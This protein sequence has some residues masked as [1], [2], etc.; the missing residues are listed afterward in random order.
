M[1]F[2][3][4]TTHSIDA[5]NDIGW[6][7]FYRIKQGVLFIQNVL[8]LGITWFIGLNKMTFLIIMFLLS[9]TVL[10]ER[11][12]VLYQSIISEILFVILFI[13]IKA[14][15]NGRQDGKAGGRSYQQL[16]HEAVGKSP[17]VHPAQNEITQSE[18]HQCNNSVNYSFYYWNCSLYNIIGG[19]IIKEMQV[20]PGFLRIN[21]ATIS[22]SSVDWT[23]KKPPTSKRLSKTSA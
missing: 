2:H 19:G 8:V 7:F 10:R 5:I 1:L 14:I 15:R 4:I 22:G 20:H 3:Y 21:T 12:C 9:V 18:M 23:G 16:Y 13:A 11:V 6:V 17:S